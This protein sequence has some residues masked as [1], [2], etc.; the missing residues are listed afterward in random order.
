MATSSAASPGT[1]S[2]AHT[3]GISHKSI[4]KSVDRSSS[5][6]YECEQSFV[7]REVVSF[8]ISTEEGLYRDATTTFFVISFL[9][10]S[11]VYSSLCS[12]PVVRE[13]LLSFR[14]RFFVEVFFKGCSGGVYGVLWCLRDL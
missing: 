4:S 13:F 3:V 14:T 9:D 2:I 12:L 8:A 5:A 6:F 10:V 7:S 11:V 1:E